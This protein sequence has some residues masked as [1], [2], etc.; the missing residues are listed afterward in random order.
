MNSDFASSMPLVTFFDDEKPVLYEHWIEWKTRGGVDLESIGLFAKHDDVVDG[1]KYR[2]AF[3]EFK[4]Y[5]REGAEW[6]QLIDYTPTLPYGGGES[7]TSL[8]VCLPVPPT[9]AREFKAVFV[10]AEDVLGQFSGPRVVGLD[11]NALDCPHQY[12]KG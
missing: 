10:Q 1:Y 12:P 2:R 4:L 5:A 3:S 9:S 7:R 6:V 11:G 8:A